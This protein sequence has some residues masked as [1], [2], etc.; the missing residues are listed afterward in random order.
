VTGANTG[1][2]YN[3]SGDFTQTGLQ[4]GVVEGPYGPFPIAGGDLSITITDG[5]DGSVSIDRYRSECTGNLF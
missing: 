1:S 3:I 4:Y 2:F 5:E